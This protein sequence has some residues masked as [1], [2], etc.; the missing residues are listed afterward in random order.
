MSLQWYP[1]S[2]QVTAEAK[3]TTSWTSILFQRHT[4]Y[5][6]VSE[7]SSLPLSMGVDAH[8]RS[9]YC[10]STFRSS[11]FHLCRSCPKLYL[12][13]VSNMPGGI[14]NYPLHVSSHVRQ[15][16]YPMSK[17]VVSGLFSLALCEVSHG[18][19]CSHRQNRIFPRWDTLQP[20]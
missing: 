10:M 1:S 18:L 12:F 2:S 6:V 17:Q 15:N 3:H 5:S 20:T 11:Y 8:G 9:G 16:A 19:L 7:L 14:Q 13:K 4:D